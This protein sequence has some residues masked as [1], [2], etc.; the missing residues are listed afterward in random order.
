MQICIPTYFLDHA[1]SINEL[2]T[3]RWLI[4]NTCWL[5]C[6]FMSHFPHRWLNDLF[7]Q[8][9]SIKEYKSLQS[10]FKLVSSSNFL[11]K[12]VVCL[13]ILKISGLDL[14]IGYTEDYF[15]GWI[16]F[17]YHPFL[18]N[19]FNAIWRFYCSWSIEDFNTV[20][21]KLV[22]ISKFPDI[23]SLMIAFLF[24]LVLL[25]DLWALHNLGDSQPRYL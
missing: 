17:K 9:S 3:L 24:E 8:S 2:T 22:W 20:A 12:Y 23:P 18:P 6:F 21:A 25:T 5:L 11:L 16:L 7:F 13:K 14:S 1:V 4:G 19:I 15:Q 10:I